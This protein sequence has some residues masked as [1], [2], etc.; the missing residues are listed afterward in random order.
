M[1]SAVGGGLAG[2]G[3]VN[4]PDATAQSGGDIGTDARSSRVAVVGLGMLGRG[5]AACFLRHGMHVVALDRGEAELAAAREVI[6]G[7][8]DELIDAGLAEPDLRKQWAARYRAVT[9][10]AELADCTFVIESVPEDRT[11]KAEALNRIEAAVTPVVVIASNTSAIPISSLQKGTSHPER[12]VGMHWAEPAHATRFMELVRGDQTSDAAFQAAAEMARRVGKEPC[13]CQKDVPG[14]IVNRIGYAMYR[15]AHALL[16]A[17]VADADSIDRAMRNSIGLWASLCGPLRWI[18]LSGG[19]ELYAKAMEPVLPSLSRD[20]QL[21]PMFAQLAASGA[22]GVR[23]G[24]GFFTYT[25]EEARQW[26]ELY[27]QH[28]WRIAK[29][30]D[31][32]FPLNVTH[33]VPV[34]LSGS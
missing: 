2:G 20:E 3:S 18:D 14:F 12:L 27:R 7:M 15:E 24:R 9:D 23:N 8:I 10:Y 19:P 4:V 31:E 13:F 17:G 33:G 34:R 22:Q 6:A 28:A 30:Q 11:T 26:S 32:Y 25:P 1:H 29:M 16:D 5:I 21:S